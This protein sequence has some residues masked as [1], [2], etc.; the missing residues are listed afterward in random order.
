[1]VYR[2][3]VLSVEVYIGEERRENEK[4]QNIKTNSSQQQQ[5]QSYSIVMIASISGTTTT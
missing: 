4:R 3:L 5:L 1:M 2:L